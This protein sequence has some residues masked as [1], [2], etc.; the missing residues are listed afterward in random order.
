M[1]YVPSAFSPAVLL[2]QQA[3][4]LIGHLPGIRNADAVSVHDARVATRRLREALPLFARAYPDDVERL[5]TLLRQAGRRL[6]RVRE[7]DVMDAGL[8]HR[9]VRLAAAIQVIGAARGAL[10]RRQER[11][12]RKLVRAF[13]SF[14][15][16]ASGAL[17]LPVPGG[18]RRRLRGDSPRGWED[19]LRDRIVARADDLRR[20]IE[21]ASGVYFPNRAHQVRVAVKKLRYACELAQASGVWRPRNLLGDLKRAQE[22]L[23]QLHDAQVL[24]DSTDDLVAETG[25]DPV[26]IRILKD[27]LSCEV[28]EHHA[29]YLSQ[30]ERLLGVCGAC[31]RM[32]GVGRAPR[33]SEAITRGAPG[34]ARGSSPRAGRA[35]PPR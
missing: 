2:A 29:R 10:A 26:Q 8:A 35:W 24:L 33:L 25:I 32:P 34:G 19:A 18:L 30:R 20:A 21:H 16:D 23:G 28:A 31:D 3:G 27:D 15:L 6:G 14:G 1:T 7:L 5:G 4:E 22:A 12:R 17:R 13:D 9:S 11:A